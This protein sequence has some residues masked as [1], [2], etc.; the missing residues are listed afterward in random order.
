MNNFPEN[1]NLETSENANIEESM[2]DDFSTV[3]SNPTEHKKSAEDFKKKRLL[4]KI[5][6]SFLAVAIL[7]GGT[8]AVIKLIPEKE[9]GTTST[10]SIEEIEVLSLKS[11]DFRNITVYNNNGTFKLYSVVDKSTSASSDSSEST[12]TV[13][14][15]IEGYK[16]DI[17]STT[18]I[19]NI[20]YSIATIS[21]SRE[22]TERS[23][24]DCGLVNPKIKALAI[25]KD[26]KNTTILLGDESPDKSGYYFKLEDSDKIY[27]VDKTLKETL[28]FTP[29]SLANT[30]ILPA[31]PLTDIS[32]TYK[33]DDGTLASFDKLTLSGKNISEPLVIT[34]FVN[35]ELSTLA[36]FK[37]ISPTKRIAENLDAVIGIFKSG[38]SVTGAYALDTTAKTLADLGLNSPDFTAKMEI[39]GKTHTFKFKLQADGGYAAICDD[40]SIVK[41]VEADS[42]PFADKQTS[43]FYSDWVSLNFIDDLKSF[44][45]KIG[46][47][48]HIFNIK[49]NPDENAEDRYIITYNGK[50]IKSS[51]F[52]DF[53]QDCISI[54]CADFTANKVT[55][56]PKYAIIYTY[57]DEIGGSET[58]EF[59]KFS[60]TK[61]QYSIDGDDLGKVTASSLNALE[62]SL[63]KL[64]ENN[65]N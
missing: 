15:Y 62:K 46:D 27:V 4:P 50:T 43:Y 36:T 35:E 24:A 18:T 19:G 58:V 32:S 34:H 8:F 17:L 26:G 38:I 49:A 20:A 33:A 30:N 45:F 52:Q 13:T 23:A 16:E 2:Q 48:S 42:I 51:P 57:K 37:I 5:I 44:T 40:S 22:V 39:E 14:W 12:E 41:K 3:F 21:A 10:P 64:I 31:F 25:D 53:Y 56:K 7:A 65:V 28:D 63:N 54:K 29:V 1:E 55:E 60:E 9:E 11:D 61:Y 47:K 6:A 59:A